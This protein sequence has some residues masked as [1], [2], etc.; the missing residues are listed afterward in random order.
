MISWTSEAKVVYTVQVSEFQNFS[1]YIIS[2]TYKADNSKA[3]IMLSGLDYSTTYFVRVRAFGSGEYGAWSNP[4]Q[5]TTVEGP[6]T[7]PRPLSPLN[8]ATNQRTRPTLQWRAMEDVYGYDVEV[9]PT[10]QFASIAFS[11]RNVQS[12]QIITSLLS[13]TLTY[14]WHVRPHIDEAQTDWSEVSSFT[15]G[16]APYSPAL[17]L[18]EHEAFSTGPVQ[19]FEW[20]AIDGAKNYHVQISDNSTFD[21]F[22]LDLRDLVGNKLTT[23][24]PGEGLVFWRVSAS[25]ETGEGTWSP[26]RSLHI[27]SS[28]LA[29]VSTP[30]ELINFV[31]KP[32][33]VSS[34]ATFGF[35]LAEP[36]GV[37]MSIHDL[38]GVELL[39]E[40]Q[41]ALSV[42]SYNIPMDLSALP[43]GVYTYLVTYNNTRY[44]GKIMI[45]R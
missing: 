27:A 32:N 28:T 22:I 14:Y 25:N 19:T 20:Q 18:P 35:T 3:L 21:K 2:T 7:S 43:I 26:W 44:M 36:G 6:A 17:N 39:S 4:I 15:T 33:P 29:D 41:P 24:I 10:T 9:S 40:T 30:S 37:R 8:G 38:N 45:V 31:M 11:A 42:G 23:T 13:P 34:Y 12:T 1:S 5:F 16:H